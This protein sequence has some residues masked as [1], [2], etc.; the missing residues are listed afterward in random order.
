MKLTDLPVRMVMGNG[1]IGARFF[2]KEHPPFT[3]DHWIAGPAHQAAIAAHNRL[4]KAKRAQTTKH[5][6][7]E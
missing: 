2:S 5:R 7:T 6:A 3:A 1:P 4:P